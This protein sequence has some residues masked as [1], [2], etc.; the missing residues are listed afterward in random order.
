MD[1]LYRLRP[2]PCVGFS[3]VVSAA[4]SRCLMLA[5]FDSTKVPTSAR[6][7]G[8]TACRPDGPRRPAR[9]RP[10]ASPSLAGRP[11]ARAGRGAAGALGHLGA[12]LAEPA[13]G[14]KHGEGG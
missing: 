10:A 1:R 11:R 8:T 12:L 13:Q 7:N 14:R 4:G 3:P 5:A 9:R 6:T 2:A